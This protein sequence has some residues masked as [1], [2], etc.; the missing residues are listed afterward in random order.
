MD[1]LKIAASIV[2]SNKTYRKETVKTSQQISPA[3]PLLASPPFAIT[4]TET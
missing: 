4:T 2:V 3:P 1:D